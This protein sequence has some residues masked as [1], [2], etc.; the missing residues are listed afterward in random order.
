MTKCYE[1]PIS[2]NIQFLIFY[3]NCIHIKNRAMEA[4]RAEGTNLIK[5]FYDYCNFYKLK[6]LGDVRFGDSLDLKL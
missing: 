2:L 3:F 5:L 1:S 6:K 4:R